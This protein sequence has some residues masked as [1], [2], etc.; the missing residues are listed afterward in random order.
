MLLGNLELLSMRGILKMLSTYGRDINN[1]NLHY[2]PT[3]YK[4][5]CLQLNILSYS[6]YKMLTLIKRYHR[7][8]LI[9]SYC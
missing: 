8:T 9:D 6:L 5:S 4:Q 2:F 1:E 7:D 3:V